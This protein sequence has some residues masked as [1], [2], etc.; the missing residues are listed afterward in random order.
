MSHVKSES[1]DT[2]KG[3]Y[4]FSKPKPHN[5]H[6]RGTQLGGPFKSHAAATRV[7]KAASRKIGEGPMS[8]YKKFIKSELRKA[9]K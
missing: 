4:L 1:F 8:E 7:S 5:P 6:H 3:I 9:K 2:D